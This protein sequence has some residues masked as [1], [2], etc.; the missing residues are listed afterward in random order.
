[1]ST[2]DRYQQQAAKVGLL[3]AWRELGRQL[4][5]L[6][7]LTGSKQLKFQDSPPGDPIGIS[8]PPLCQFYVS[9]SHGAFHVTMT[10]PQN[11]NPVSVKVMKLQISA[12]QQQN[13]NAA[14]VVYNL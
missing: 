7:A 9:G 2:I 1:M 5:L 14:P 3:D 11:V 12:L 4:D 6:S 10:P 13:L 8:L